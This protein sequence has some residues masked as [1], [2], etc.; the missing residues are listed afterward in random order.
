MKTMPG[1]RSHDL[2]GSVQYW[3]RQFDDARFAVALARTAAT[4]GAVVLNHCPVGSLLHSDG[5]LSGASITD[6][7]AA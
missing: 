1:V 2:V 5:K 6:S 4:H 7:E 3:D